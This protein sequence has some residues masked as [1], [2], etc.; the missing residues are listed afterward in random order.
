M[1]I[2]KKKSDNLHKKPKF[3]NFALYKNLK[4]MKKLIGLVLLLVAT[5]A[6]FA[7]QTYT[8]SEGTLKARQEFADSKFGIFLHWGL[9]STFAQGEW[10]LSKGKL[11]HQEYKK[12]ADAFYPHNFD[13]K[14]WVKAIKD[15][16]AKYICFTSRHHEG[17]SM[18]D[19]D[20]SKYD[21]VDAT[22]FK[23]D[24]IKELA[25]ECHRQGIKLHLYYSHV[26]WS[27]DDYPGGYSTIKVRD[28]DHIEGGW[29]NYY[30]FMNSQLTELLTRYGKIG[31]IWFDGVWDHKKA[32]EPFNW[33][34]EE[35]YRHIHKLQPD[36]LI[37]N[38]HHLTPFEGEDFQIFE[39][40]LPGENKAGL[41]GQAVSRLPLETCQTMNK[42]WGYKVADQN[43]KSTETLIRYLVTTSGKGANL[44]LNVG[45]QPNGELPAAALVRLKEMGEWLRANGETIYG[46]T[47]GDISAQEWG[48]TTRKGNRLFVHIFDLKSQELH[49]P[50]SCKVSKAFAYDSKQAVKFV[51]SKEGGITLKFDEVPSGI[52]YIVELITK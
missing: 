21:I 42:S 46:T 13:A 25:R 6:S 43:Y 35:Q 23:R 36:C 15:A 1:Q 26:D 31:A 34:L 8:P 10:Y 51:K 47:A 44:L 41:S 33:Q 49:L 9:Y 29:P 19:T 45:P 17:F 39:R 7:Q 40:D 38:N 4:I 11:S 30:N 52:D 2:Y 16:G 32:K 12:A 37:G 50:L 20:C 22:P 5:T 27:R 18:W 28:R 24:I 14:A 48:V 3:V